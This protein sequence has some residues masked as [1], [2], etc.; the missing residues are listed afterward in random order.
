M[1]TNKSNQGE[2]RFMRCVR[3]VFGKKSAAISDGASEETAAPANP[4]NGKK[5][6]IIDDDP[7]FVKATSTMLLYQGYEVVAAK[8]GSEAI[9]AMREEKPNLVLMDINLD[10]GVSTVSWDGFTLMSWLRRFEDLRAVPIVM[11]SSG[12]PLKFVRRALTEGAK[13]FFHKSTNPNNLVSTL[14]LLLFERYPTAQRP[15]TGNFQI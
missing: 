6:L 2:T 4:P 11:V 15:A 7:V 13:A 10:S 3:A 5:I 9:Q 12:D 8:D 14:R 1:K